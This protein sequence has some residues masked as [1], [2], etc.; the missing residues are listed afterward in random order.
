MSWRWCFICA[1]DHENCISID[2][3][4]I[5]LYRKQEEASQTLNDEN[6]SYM[7]VYCF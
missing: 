5:P 6:C 4:D 3:L 2:H 7:L 1:N